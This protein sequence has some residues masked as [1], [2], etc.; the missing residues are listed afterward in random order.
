MKV[1]HVT[2]HPYFRATRTIMQARWS[3]ESIIFTPQPSPQNLSAT[4]KKLS[5]LGLLKSI[6]PETQAIIFHEQGALNYLFGVAL[7]LFILK[8]KIKI[9]Y[10]IHDIYSHSSNWKI[11]LK[12]PRELIKEILEKYAFNNKK[13]GLLTVSNGL[14]IY[15]KNKYARQPEV[16]RSISEIK[17]YKP[18][19]I[20]DKLVYFGAGLTIFPLQIM[21]I[22]NSELQID[23]YDFKNNLQS[24]TS[25]YLYYA[26]PYSSDD[27]SFLSGYLALIVNLNETDD[28]TAN[29]NLRHSL[30]NKFFQ[31]LSRCLPVVAHGDFVEAE[32]YFREIDGFYYKWSGQPSDLLNIMKKIKARNFGCS[33]NDIKMITNFLRGSEEFSK[34]TYLNVIES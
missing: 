12:K 27:L 5:Y 33:E 34:K 1:I 26:G 21:P 11:G 25:K 9:V 24:C 18:N 22:L 2:K 14:S 8:K 32:E 23:Y 17:I 31:S 7:I 13:I 20:R 10:D 16:V 4:N 28:E 3:G 15:L 30:P 6:K 19:E 29:Y